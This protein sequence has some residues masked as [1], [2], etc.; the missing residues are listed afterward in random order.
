MEE[1]K[2]DLREENSRMPQKNPI[3]RTKPSNRGRFIAYVSEGEQEPSFTFHSSLDQANFH[4]KLQLKLYLVNYITKEEDILQ[5]QTFKELQ[6]ILL[7]GYMTDGLEFSAKVIDSHKQKIHNV[8]IEEFF[9]QLKGDVIDMLEANRRKK[10]FLILSILQKKG[11]KKEV[12]KDI[13]SFL[14]TK[15]THED[16]EAVVE[17]NSSS[18]EDDWEEEEDGASNENARDVLGPM[19]LPP[20]GLGSL[21][22]QLNEQERNILTELD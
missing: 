17:V 1:E 8:N 18:D 10:N 4:I 22:V 3:R 2:K 13:Y 9:A 7:H 15:L 21:N 16:T 14:P 11:L 5:F 20:I 6:D 19:R 12:I